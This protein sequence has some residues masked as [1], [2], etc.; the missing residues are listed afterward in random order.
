MER[1]VDRR[2]VLRTS[3]IA[4]AGAVAGCSGDSSDDET[5]TTEDGTAEPTESGTPDGTETPS[6]PSVESFLSNTSN[7]DGREDMT[8]SDSVGIDVGTEANGAYYGFSPAAIRVDTGTTVTWTWTG[9]GGIHN[10][11]AQHGADFA[12]EQTSEEGYTFEQTFDSTGTVLYA[13]V[14]HKGAGMKGAVIVE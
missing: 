14:P 7:F 12:S 6:Q 9:Q 2:T 3:G 11:A 1:S 13:C 4:L 5:E 8:G 10:V